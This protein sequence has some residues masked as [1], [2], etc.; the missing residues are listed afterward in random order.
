ML[1]SW[2]FESRPF[3]MQ[4]PEGSTA[5]VPYDIAQ[6]SAEELSL[7]KP[8]KYALTLKR[9]TRG[10]RSM[11][12]LW[13]GDVPVDAE[14]YR[15]LG[16]GPEGTWTFDKRVFRTIPAVMNVRLYGMNANGKVYV[17]DKIFRVGP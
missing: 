17:L 9:E 1:N 3:L 7:S 14:G 4:E 2:K 10:T 15:V 8:P 11:L 16:T 13:T 12:Y 6:P 5:K